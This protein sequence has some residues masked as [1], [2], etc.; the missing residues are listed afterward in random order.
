MTDTI[1]ISRT[2]TYLIKDK[3]MVVDWILLSVI[4]DCLK[5]VGTVARVTYEEAREGIEITVSTKAE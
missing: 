5:A 3:D 2:A 4:N 1:E